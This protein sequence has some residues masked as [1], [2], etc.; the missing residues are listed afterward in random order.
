MLAPSLF[1]ALV[2]ASAGAAPHAPAA[3]APAARALS[4]KPFERTPERR[5]RGRYLA[6]GVL[7]CLACHS[8]R[9]W[10]KP[11]APPRDGM[12]AAGQ[13]MRDEPGKRIV[14]PNITPDRETGAGTWPDDALARAIR[15]GVGHDGRTLHP[16]MWYRSFRR[17][18][19]ADVAAVVVYLRSLPPVRRPLP[20]TQWDAAERAN[21]AKSLKPLKDPVPDP[22]TGPLERGR[23]FVL[24]ADCQGCHTS[25]YSKRQP[26]LYG[27]G[28]LIERGTRHAFSTNITH[29]ASGVMADRDA[30]IRLMRTG[31]GGT[32]SPLMPW[33]VFAHLDDDDLDAIRL[34]LAQLP[35]VSHYVS[36]AL[37][38]THCPVC[39]QEH[40]LGAGNHIVLPEAKA[41]LT[42]AQ[43]QA[44]AGS[45]R[46]RE[47]G[48]ID[49]VV[50][51]DGKLYRGDGADRVE[52]VA[53]SPTAFK[54]S[55]LL[56]PLHFELDAQG[57]AM[58][59]VED[60]LEPYVFDRVEPAPARH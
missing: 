20:K 4:A 29:D 24:L 37:P 32:L 36:N 42:V 57:R 51:A 1:A 44:L 54:G 52:L 2:L 27:G 18:S 9:D 53:Q 15:E 28:N 26:G 39:L 3:G 41:T 11:G 12:V 5:A 13:V 59:M 6:E 16:Q 23:Y 30:F 8:E 22:G 49:T 25:W 19:D 48:A 21:V 45:Y 38:P 55:G 35:P 33:V 47:D 14:A 60:D 10:D 17:L 56:L 43:M 31:K 50:F 58:R 7:Q 34:V 46:A 40:G